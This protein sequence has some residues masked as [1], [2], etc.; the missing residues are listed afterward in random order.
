MFE[1]ILALAIPVA[2]Q[3]AEA[4]KEDL[5]AETRLLIEELRSDDLEVRARAQRVLCQ[6]AAD[7]TTASALV[8][9]IE[10]ALK[11]EKDIEVSSRLRYVLNSMDPDVRYRV[12]LANIDRCSIEARIELAEY[13]LS[14][15]AYGIA[16]SEFRE[17]AR[18]DLK[19]PKDL[20]RRESTANLILRG[21][22]TI[23]AKE[24][25]RW[26]DMLC[27]LL[28]KQYAGTTAQA[29]VKGLRD[30]IIKWVIKLSS[31][32]REQDRRVG[33]TLKR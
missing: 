28:D 10:E 16:V 20:V 25:S 33:P 4:G 12:H 15:G 7:D 6:T 30:I 31:E 14:M 1:V 17:A 27:D 19:G 2:V 18:L 5:R 22:K 23:L 8:P 26:V 21:A 11:G 29:E 32:A 9:L 13:C 24:P 3:Q